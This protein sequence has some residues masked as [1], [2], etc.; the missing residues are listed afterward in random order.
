[1]NNIP[2]INCGRS[3]LRAKLDYKGKGSKMIFVS[4]G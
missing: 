2:K 4:F 1:M 3:I